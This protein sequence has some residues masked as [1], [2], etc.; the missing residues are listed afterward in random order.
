MVLWRFAGE[1]YAVVTIGPPLLLM[2]V[3]GATFVEV[4]LLG[5][6]QGDELREWWARVCTWLVILA[7]AW[8][9]FFGVTLYGPM[10][11]HSP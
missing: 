8:L 11:D 5:R 3:V 6:W 9:A 1:P 4:W 2:V 7:A 10:A